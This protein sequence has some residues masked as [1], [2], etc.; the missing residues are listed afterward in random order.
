[1]AKRR[2]ALVGTAPSSAH[3]PFD[4]PSWEIWGVGFRGE[5]FTRADRWFELHRI[6]GDDDGQ[7]WVDLL[8]TWSHDCAV[9]MIWPLPVGKNV[10]QYPH[11]KIAG[12]YGT[13]FL[14]SSF[15]WMIALAIE[16][17]VDEIGVW[18]VDMEYGTEYREQR[19]G[20]RHF[21]ALAKF[22]GIKVTVLLNG[23][24]AYEPVPYPFW[25]DD[26]LLQK[27]KYRRERLSEEKAVRDR[28]C[29]S[30]LERLSQIGA[31][32]AELGKIRG[33]SKRIA[34][35]EGE[36]RGMQT[37]LPGLQKDASWSEGAIAEI[38]WM[39]DFLKP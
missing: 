34:E 8:K 4:D 23:G 24:V 16:E 18:G 19:A 5:H 25:I 35:L 14:T 26:P 38:E 20:V 17:G 29:A 33:T 30:T 21:M 1:M 22:A 9:W 10:I 3:A 39:E 15:G 31:I 6:E 37:H 27:L 28:A 11:Q 13:F 36:A 7:E 12:K 2:V 32:T